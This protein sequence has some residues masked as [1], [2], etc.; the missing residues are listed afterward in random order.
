M[1][2]TNHYVEVKPVRAID[3][4]DQQKREL[5]K[6]GYRLPLAARIGRGPLTT[7]KGASIS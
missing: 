3:L 1:R 4:T 2:Q 7:F 5:V 6:L